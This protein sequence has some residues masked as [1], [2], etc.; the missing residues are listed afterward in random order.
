MWHM[1][2]TRVSWNFMSCFK[3]QVQCCTGCADEQVYF[4]KQKY[5]YGAGC[6]MQTSKS[7]T[8][9]YGKSVQLGQNIVFLKETH[10]NKSLIINNLTL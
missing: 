9:H 4:V 10:K 7:V 1:W 6:V 8:V 2:Q 3:S 5:A